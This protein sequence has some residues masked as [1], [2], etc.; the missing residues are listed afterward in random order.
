VFLVHH[1]TLREDGAPIEGN[2][3]EP[4]VNV[5]KPDWQQ[6]LAQY[7]DDPNLLSAVEQEFAA[8]E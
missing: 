6:Q 8:F 7:F 4:M 2:G 1:L 5:Q 3:V